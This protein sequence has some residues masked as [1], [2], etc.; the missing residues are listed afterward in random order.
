MAPGRA[1]FAQDH[2]TRLAWM[3]SGALLLLVVLLVPGASAAGAPIAGGPT[4]GLA[5]VPS[6]GTLIPLAQNAAYT[7]HGASVPVAPGTLIQGALSFYGRDPAGQQQAVAAIYTPGS[8]EFHHF[9]TGSEWSTRFGPDPADQASLRSY[10]QQNGVE[11][12]PVS[13]LLWN[14]QGS[15]TA[16]GQAFGTTFVV[17]ASGGASTPSSSSTLSSTYAPSGPLQLPA[18]LA[19]LVAVDGGFQTQV[20]PHPASLREVALPP[21][22]ALPGASPSPSPQIP[23]AALTLTLSDAPWTFT[24]TSATACTVGTDSYIPAG[25]NDTYTLSISGGTPPY[26]LS[27]HWSDGSIQHFTA[28]T[29]TFTANHM[30]YQPSQTDYCWPGSAW[31]GSCQ[32]I[33]VFATDGAGDNGSAVIWGFPAGT[34]IQDPTF[35]NAETLYRMGYSGQG[36]Q[37]GIDDMCDPNYHTSSYRPD[38]TNFSN[39]FGLPL[40]KLTLIGSGSTDALCKKG[41][42]GWSGETLLDIEWA[43]SIAPNATIVLDLSNSAVDEGDATWNTLSN[44]VFIASNSW[45]GGYTTSVW[46]T[47]AAQGQ[48]YLTASGDCGGGTTNF[49]PADNPDGGGVGGTQIYPY[50]AGIFRAEYAWNGSNYSPCSN[51]DG[52]TGGY[53]TTYTAP[54]YQIGMQGFSNAQRGV[55]DFAALGGT[56]VAVFQTGTGTDGWT[57]TA[58]TSLA[59]PSFAAMLD[60]VYQYNGTATS[61]NGLFDYDAYAIAKGANYDTG[62]HDIVVGNNLVKGVGYYTTVGWDPVTGLGSPNIGELAQ[63]VALQNGNPNPFSA[64]TTTIS[65]NVSFGPASL[66]VFLGADVAGGPPSLTGYSYT[67][68]FGDCTSSATTTV[69]YTTHAYTYQGTFW[70]TVTVTAS[71]YVGSG[72]SNSVPIHVSTGV[73]PCPS[74]TGGS[75]TL[76]RSGPGETSYAVTLSAPF[77]GGT[78]PYTATF[79]WGDGS[80]KTITNPTASAAVATHVYS[81]AGTFSPKVYINDSTS[82]SV[83]DVPSAPLTVYAHVA[84][85]PISV[86]SWHGLAPANL[87]FSGGAASSGLGPYTYAWSYVCNSNFPASCSNSSTTASGAPFQIFLH[88]GNFSVSL[89][90]T[91]SLAYSSSFTASFS[92]WGNSSLPLALSSGWNLVALPLA[93]NDYTL[94]ELA[95]ELGGSTLGAPLLSLADLHGGTTTAYARGGPTGNTAVPAGDALWVDLSAPTSLMTYG[96]RASSISGVAFTG[97]T[98]SGVGWSITGTT[99]ASGLAALLGAPAGL[100]AVSEW[101]AATQSWSTYLYGFDSPG[102]QYDFTLTQG[103]AVYLWT[104]SGGTFTE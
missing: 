71:G 86:S 84:V 7:A 67:W 22:A 26:D 103:T 33:T 53:S 2:R 85:A 49:A 36:T 23:H 65:T 30:F 10:L 69:P 58:G 93:T 14:I 25:E 72:T 18:H 87:T 96:L 76:N 102:G 44:G 79:L 62:W 42:K 88:P 3:S 31:P 64:I 52:S 55:P 20:G 92:A 15:A 54:W 9:Y 17:P 47:A 4:S 81:T 74:M 40:G 11:V 48:T 75:A 56:N 63:F 51:A 45:G 1:T 82:L 28:S 29:G 78:G 6:M 8:P 80:A 73:S 39:Q 41:S 101:N 98:W 38:L 50:P 99:T 13:D 19:Q 59:C 70:P 100:T 94:F 27:W 16:M 21:G 77:S 60:L 89:K 97:S 90:V 37:I 95:L 61:P 34:A 91:D 5:P 66:S 43:H 57:I 12:S 46:T 35:Y 24:C 83:A 32:N 104:W 68:N